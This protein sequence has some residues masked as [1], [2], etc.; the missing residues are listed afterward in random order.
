MTKQNNRASLLFRLALST[1]LGT[2]L[3]G[4]IHSASAQDAAAGDS[5]TPAGVSVPDS[6]GALERVDKAHEKELQKQWKTAAELY[7]EAISK[8]PG[9]VIPVLRDSDRQIYQYAGI[10]MLVQERISKWPADGLTIYRN[11]YGQT[12]ADLLSAVP[13]GNIAGLENIFWNYFATDA[14]KTAGL[15]LIDAN[16]EC[17][18]FQAAK[19]F[20]N[21][22]LSLHPSL[23]NDRGAITYRTAVACYRAGDLKAANDLLNNLKQQN[24]TDVASIAGKDVSLVDSLSAMLATPAPRPTTAPSDA[25]TYP[26]FGGP[27]GRGEVSTSSAKPGASLNSIVLN[28]PEAT[29]LVGAQGAQFK[30]NETIT[31]SNY[32]AMGIMPVVDAGALFFQDGRSIYAVDADSGAPLPGWLNTYGSDRDGRYRINVPGRVRGEP[33]TI[34]VT[35]T[36]VLAV[37]GQPDRMSNPVNPNLFMMQQPQGPAITTVKLVCLDRDT[38]KELWTRTPAD[39]LEPA[40]IRTGHYSGTPLVIPA[41]LTPFGEDCVMVIARGGPENQFDDCY[42]IC[43]SLK[44]GQY[45]WSTYLGSATRNYE[46]DGPTSDP[47]QTSLADGRIFVMTNLGTVASLNPADGR[48]L[49]L[50]SYS[51]DAVM[52]PEQMFLRARQFNN[53]FPQQGQSSSNSA[54][55][56]N[57]VFVSD[58]CVFALPRDAKEL[59]IYDAGSGAEKNRIPTSA[60][61]NAGVMLGARD[62]AVC[63]TSDKG[64]YVINWAKYQDGDQR[65]ATRWHEPDVTHNEGSDIIGRGFITSDSVFLPT[66]NRLIQLT[67]KSGKTLAFYPS[68]GNF[69]GDQ[70]PGNI[71]V[72]SHNVVVAGQKYVDVYTDLSMVRLR[73]ESQIAAAPGDPKPLL[74]YAYALFNGGDRQGATARVDQAID[75]IGGLNAMRPGKDRE[76]VFN[77]MLDFAGRSEKN[78]DADSMAWGNKFFD[79]AAAAADSPL[80]NAK[81]R[82]ARAQFDHANHDYTAELDLC[83]QVLS[84]PGMRSAMVSDEQDGATAA[85]TAIGVVIALNASVYEPI[86]QR[87][88]EALATARQANDADQLLAVATVYPNSKAASDARQDA[89]HR[90]EADNQPDKAI[91]VLRRMYLG[92]T[93]S[94]ERVD[95]LVNIANDFLAMPDGVGPAVDRLC[96]ASKI[97][98]STKITQKLHLP[99]GN[100]L[101]DISFTDAIAKLRLVQAEQDNAKL[102]DFHI[103]IPTDAHQLD[104]FA[105]STP[106]DRIE[107]VFAIVHPLRDFA[108]AD[109]IL[110]WGPAGLSIYPAGGTTAV[111]TIAEIAKAPV[112]CAW[113]RD[114]WLVWTSSDL[115]KISPDAKLIWDF[116]LVHM[117]V[118]MVS[119][120]G[121]S[122]QDVS[123]ESASDDGLVANGGNVQIIN[124][125]VFRLRGNVNFRVMRNGVPVQP[126]IAPP[127]VAVRAGEEEIADVKPAADRILITTTTGRLIGLETRSGQIVW[128]TR[129]VDHTADALMANPHFTAVRLDDSAGSQ[130]AV[131]DTQTGRV[132]GRIRFGAEGSATQLVNAALS[133]EGTLAMTLFNQLMIKDLYDKW[134]L[135]AV[136]L[137]AQSN[138]DIAPY[139]GMTQSDQLLIHGG[140]IACLYDAGAFARAWDLATAHDPTDPKST[141]PNN[142]FVSMRMIGP[143]LYIQTGRE[144]RQYNLADATDHYVATTGESDFPPRLHQVM[145]G[146]DFSLTINDPVDRG[147]AGQPFVKLA[148]YER[149][150]ITQAKEFGEALYLTTIRDQAGIMDWIGNE[151]GVAYLTKDNVLHLRRGT[152]K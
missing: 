54:W 73:Y 102:P 92:S 101:S 87:A 106:A 63:L 21:R 98:P 144:L 76:A 107:N 95:I 49:W 128:Q 116:P 9:R 59:F 152:R 22:L 132:V 93:S 20:G 58:G 149:A 13:H 23:G 19:W 46:P 85:E 113:S 125:Q 15:R 104:P 8:Y 28:K 10:A 139:T 117:P 138:R 68:E 136:T 115:Y 112:A 16:L 79:R 100:T 120:G 71:L 17:G 55:A 83:Q 88:T 7:Q 56:Q 57:P 45:K 140:R 70:G 12:A 72:T 80:Q 137:G 64:V 11:T 69:T 43:L 90:F 86:E 25:D 109:Q 131:Y 34:T 97:A 31:L 42:A 3:L 134:S 118:L 121:D 5:S 103:T 39:L 61:D 127:P 47:S 77:I 124:G 50:N 146:R 91:A 6:P 94:G 78:K 82:L 135:P 151:G 89:V 24:P 48:I 123:G 62:G 75:L 147:P 29:G 142:G 44:T 27:G 40:A 126:P 143:R 141:G 122:V 145:L 66:K 1:A 96:R 38:G 32:Q 35:P 26:S 60:Y 14:G 65:I 114:H 119:T 67:W 150:P 36:S 33:T 37:I 129:P 99:D 30:Q 84:D 52:N 105:L 4:S 81:Y 41:R 2:N 51:R 148:A 110:T 108:R 74:A 130:I 111:G 53:G 18:D 133:E